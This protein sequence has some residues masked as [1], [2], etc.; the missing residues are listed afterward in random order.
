MRALLTPIYT[1]G[2]AVICRRIEAE[3]SRAAD[4]YMGHP[5][6]N[7]PRVVIQ[8]SPDGHN[9]GYGG[10]GPAD[11]AL[12][13]LTLHMP[14]GADQRQPVE[15]WR[16]CTSAFAWRHHQALKREV[17]AG[18]PY[19]GGILSAETIRAFIDRALALDL[20]LP[21]GIGEEGGGL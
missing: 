6:T 5:A 9:W 8:H 1:P 2:G 17:I 18:L 19:E 15:C 12:D 14:P 3:D 21:D 13:I 10:A 7:V 4:A 11:L 20:A 16:G